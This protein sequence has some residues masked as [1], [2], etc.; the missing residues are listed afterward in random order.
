MEVNGRASD[1][2]DYLSFLIAG[3]RSRW[4]VRLFFFSVTNN[5]R[6]AWPGA[7]LIEADAG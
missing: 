6:P 5:E 4:H 1:E 2:M 7:I 3:F